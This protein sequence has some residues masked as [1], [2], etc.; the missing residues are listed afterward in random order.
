[1]NHDIL[2][3]YLA[4]VTVPTYPSLPILVGSDTFQHC[5]A[6]EYDETDTLSYVDM[7]CEVI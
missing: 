2:L 7:L 4:R 3:G 5:A 6:R 1:M